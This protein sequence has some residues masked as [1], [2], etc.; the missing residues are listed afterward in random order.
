MGPGVKSALKLSGT[1]GTQGKSAIAFANSNQLVGYQ[2]VSK[3]KLGM[4][5][6]PSGGAGAR[7]A[8]VTFERRE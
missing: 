2:A 7:D 8:R 6:Y 5:M 1:S 4:A 3:S